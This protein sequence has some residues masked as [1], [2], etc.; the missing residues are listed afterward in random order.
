MSCLHLSVF[1]ALLALAG[2]AGPIHTAGTKELPPHQRAVLTAS[3]H[4]G[5]R[6]YGFDRV[7]QLSVDGQACPLG[8]KPTALWLTPAA[9]E[10]VVQFSRGD[11]AVGK[12][13]LPLQAAVGGRYELSASLQS[14]GLSCRI[15]EAET[16]ET[17]ARGHVQY[18]AATKPAP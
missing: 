4:V 17:A 1:V 12:A 11:G 18:S 15:T 13:V 10:V 3:S 6:N 14:S 7:T 2:C 16:K 8:E 9:H 5:G